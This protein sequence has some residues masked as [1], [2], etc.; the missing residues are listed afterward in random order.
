MTST[1]VSA[2]E[3]YRGKAG[4][5]SHKD[6]FWIW[7]PVEEAAAVEHLKRFLSAFQSSPATK[8]NPLEVE[9]LGSNAAELK[10]IFKESFFEIPHKTSKRNIPVAILRYKAG[11]LNSRKAMVSPF[12]PN[13]S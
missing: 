5:Y 11:T 8:N 6:E 7:I 9:F 13:L 4:S 1:I 2:E 3:V 12:L 10:M